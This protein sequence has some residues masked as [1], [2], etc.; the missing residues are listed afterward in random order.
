MIVYFGI[1]KTDV[2]NQMNRL[3]ARYL[4]DHYSLVDLQVI[5]YDVAESKIVY[6]I[7]KWL[8]ID[9]LDWYDKITCREFAHFYVEMV[10]AVLNFKNF[11]D[12]SAGS[13]SDN[14]REA[15]LAIDKIEKIDNIKYSIYEDVCKYID[16][17]V[18]WNAVSKMPCDQKIKMCIMKRS[19]DNFNHQTIKDFLCG[20]D[21]ENVSDDESVASSGL[22]SESESEEETEEVPVEV[23]EKAEVAEF[24]SEYESESESEGDKSHRSSNTADT[25]SSSLSSDESESG[26]EL[27]VVS[28]EKCAEES[29]GSYSYSYEYSQEGD[30]LA[31]YEYEESEYESGSG[32]NEGGV[33]EENILVVEE[34]NIKPNRDVVKIITFFDS[35]KSASK[36]SASSRSSCAKFPSSSSFS[37]E[38]DGKIVVVDKDS[39]SEGDSFSNWSTSSSESEEVKTIFA[40]KPVATTQAIFYEKWASDF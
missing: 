3:F 31:E 4:L 27:I 19:S 2:N 18:L 40:P 20:Y 21:Y 37:E 32:E 11:G 8:K 9:T 36:Q 25:K 29:E 10:D 5:N 16:L 23:E 12:K 35:I 30:S 22:G 33:K 15:I 1:F 38:D 13:N 14:I 24:I 7:E 34:V 17:F 39:E 6:V 28:V 26:S